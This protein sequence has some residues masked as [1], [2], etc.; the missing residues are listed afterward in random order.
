MLSRVALQIDFAEW[1]S[2]LYHRE[3]EF[4]DYL[5]AENGDVN[6]AAVHF[7]LTIKEVQDAREALCRRWLAYSNG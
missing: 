3:Q 1:A 6:E 2:K 7:G 5:A 4:L